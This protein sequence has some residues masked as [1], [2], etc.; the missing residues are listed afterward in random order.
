MYLKLNEKKYMKIYITQDD[1]RKIRKYYPEIFTL[2]MYVI[3]T[4]MIKEN[5]KNTLS[6]HNKIDKYD[7]FIINEVINKNMHYAY[8]SKRYGNVLYIVDKVTRT[9]LYNIRKYLKEN[10]IFFTEFVLIDISENLDRKLYKF[11]DNVI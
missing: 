5:I 2:G 6:T 10:D 8:N 9:F 11:F 4:P 3:D 1:R 7:Y